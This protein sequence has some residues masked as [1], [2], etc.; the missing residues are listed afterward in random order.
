MLKIIENILACGCFCFVTFLKSVYVL[1]KI[2]EFVVTVI[3][4]LGLFGLLASLDPEYQSL[5]LSIGLPAMAFFFLC[6]IGLAFWKQERFNKITN[7][8]KL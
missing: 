7:S 4:V 1:A 6:F 3:L 8:F 5:V 2:I